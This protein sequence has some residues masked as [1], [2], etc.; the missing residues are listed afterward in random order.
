M[1]FMKL[2]EPRYINFI[3]NNHSRKIFFELSVPLLFQKF[4]ITLTLDDEGLDIYES[5]G[6][7]SER[8]YLEDYAEGDAVTVNIEASSD[9]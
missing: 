6:E 7:V 1:K 2:A 3:R 8:I 9:E 4:C 5:V